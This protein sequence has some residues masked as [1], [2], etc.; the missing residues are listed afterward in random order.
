MLN[1]HIIK[2]DLKSGEVRYRTILTQSGKGIKTKTFRR[3][4]DACVFQ[5]RLPPKPLEC[6][7]LNRSKKPPYRSV[8]TREVY[9][10]SISLVVVKF[11]CC[12]L[13]ESPSNFIL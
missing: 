12:F 8:A 2:V 4:Q 13:S 1:F 3:K 6:G 10:Y 9:F 5:S 7:H 11:A